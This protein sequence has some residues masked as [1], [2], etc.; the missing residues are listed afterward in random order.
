MESDAQKARQ[1]AAV[2]R[3]EAQASGLDD[4]MVALV[5]NEMVRLSQGEE[6]MACEECSKAMVEE[7]RFQE[8]RSPARME[9]GGG[10]GDIEERLESV[11]QMVAMGGRYRPPNRQ[12]GSTGGYVGG[13]KNKGGDL[14]FEPLTFSGAAN[15]ELGRVQLL[16]QDDQRA[17]GQ[18]VCAVWGDVSSTAADDLT[19]IRCDVLEGDYPVSRDAT[20]IPLVRFM[21]TAAGEVQPYELGPEAS[22][23]AGEDLTLRPYVPEGMN[24]DMDDTEEATLTAFAATAGEC[25]PA[26]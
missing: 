25:P 15:G 9:S 20:R 13:A 23:A 21:I 3:E 5:G 11:E 12:R 8:G 19:K 24:L 1:T 18:R 4:R 17:W 14:G 22:V 7:T 6:E 16:Q 10:A 26:G 2:L